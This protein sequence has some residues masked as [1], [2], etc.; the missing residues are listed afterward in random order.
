MGYLLT[1]FIRMNRLQRILYL[2][3]R[4]NLHRL[5]L[6]LVIII[7]ITTICLPLLEPNISYI[8]AFWW[9]IVTLTT[10]G[11]GD[12]TPTSVAGKTIGIL[13]MF[14]GIGLLGMITATIASIFIEKKQKQERGMNSFNF[15]NHIIICEWNH[16]AKE[17]IYELRNDHRIGKSPII[18]IAD[19]E[20]KPVDDQFLF[21]IRGEISEENLKKANID[22]ANTV[23]ILGNDR[24]DPNARDARVVLTTLTVE[25]INP[26][27]YT[28]VELVD[29]A[30]IRYCERANADEMIVGREFSSKLISRAA[31]DHGISKVVSELLSS[32][33][34]ND[35]LKIPIKESQIGKKFIDIFTEMK[36]TNNSIV[37]GIQKGID[38]AVISNP[39]VDFTIDNGDFLIVISK[40]NLTT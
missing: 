36:C 21:F 33:L 19:L 7:L 17:I 5:L 12:I 6:F 27:V 11:Y 30:N 39:P 25:S 20:I 35:L 32:H 15:V 10:V 14:F 16:R 34:G 24:L 18:L 22:K 29:S 28:I 38:G 40:S 4:E 37:L 2:I 26:K 23:I 31:V 8:N 3:K 1:L 9:T 13:I